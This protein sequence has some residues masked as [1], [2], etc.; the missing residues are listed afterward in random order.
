MNVKLGRNDKCW[1]GSG[2]KYKKCH[3][4]SDR[5]APKDR[6]GLEKTAYLERWKGNANFFSNMGHYAWMASKLKS[7]N[8]KLFFD[9]GCGDGS[10]IIALLDEFNH[11]DIKVISIDEN[12]A[13]LNSAK[14]NIEKAGY[15]A[16]IIKRMDVRISNNGAH[17]IF[18]NPLHINTTSQVILIESDILTDHTIINSLKEY[19][20]F[21]AVTVWLIGTHMERKNCSNLASLNIRSS[22][23][24]RLFVQNRVYEIADEILHKGGVLQVVD[25]TEAPT[26]DMIKN[27]F[28]DAHKEQASVTSLEFHS[29]DYIL[30]SEPKTGNRV[31][32]ILTKGASGKKPETDETSISSFISMK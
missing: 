24:Y 22:G 21:D 31:A 26:T 14:D 5:T 4:T 30:Y 32:M 1:C 17:E 27:D 29:L 12:I 3:L 25:R 6:L 18:H 10:G 11:N 8:P 2:L 9:I 13:C 20:E 16:E 7:F 15:T 23:E 28:I 19:G